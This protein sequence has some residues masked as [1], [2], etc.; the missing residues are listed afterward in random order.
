MLRVLSSAGVTALMPQFVPNPG[1]PE[2]AYAQYQ[3]VLA[4]ENFYIATIAEMTALEASSA[5]VRNLHITSLGDMPLIV[6]S[7]GDSNATP[8]LS[9]T[10]NQQMWE[11]WQEMQSKLAQLSSDNKQVI[12]EQSGHNIQLDQ[13]DLVINAVLEIV[14]IVRK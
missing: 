14:N 4:K 5:E 11:V 10:E 6:L 2:D 12:A 8:L 3:A 7:R 13:P 9:D 1:L